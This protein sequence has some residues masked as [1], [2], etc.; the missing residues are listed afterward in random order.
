MRL[1]TRAA[2][3]RSKVLEKR[4][5]VAPGSDR[6]L[7]ELLFRYSKART[8]SP[9]PIATRPFQAQV[10][11]Y[12]IEHFDGRGTLFH[13]KSRDQEVV[14]KQID[15]SR[16]APGALVDLVQQVGWEH[17]LVG[18]SGSAQSRFDVGSHFITRE[19]IQ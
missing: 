19:Q 13:R 9:V 7:R 17:A 16:Y 12:L 18:H 4:N 6:S 3:Q 15:E 5:L 14:A 1:L 8:P 11:A 2:Y 10:L